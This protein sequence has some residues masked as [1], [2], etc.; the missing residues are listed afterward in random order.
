MQAIETKQ[1]NEGWWKELRVRQSGK[2]KGNVFACYSN[3]A[4]QVYYS[5]TKAEQA[6][7]IDTEPDKRK[8]RHE[9]KDKGKNKTKAK[10]KKKAAAEKKATAK[11]KAS[12]KRKNTKPKDPESAEESNDLDSD[13]MLGSAASEKDGNSDGDSDAD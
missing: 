5:R 11:K 10:T 12:A 13:E 9:G 6:G 8:T 4:G 2:Q 7:C 1:L 3:S